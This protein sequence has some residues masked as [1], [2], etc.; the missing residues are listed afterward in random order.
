MR[1]KKKLYKKERTNYLSHSK[2][3]II[4][5]TYADGLQHH[6]FYKLVQKNQILYVLKHAN[7][8]NLFCLETDV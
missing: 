3:V 7:F 4:D 1:L 8:V 5:T 6:S 2:K